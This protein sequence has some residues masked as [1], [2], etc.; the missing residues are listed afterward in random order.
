LLEL[1]AVVTLLV[2]KFDINFAPGVDR[3]AVIEGTV[4]HFAS[5]PGTLELVFTKR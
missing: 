3:D 2:T 4:D 5:S 1:R